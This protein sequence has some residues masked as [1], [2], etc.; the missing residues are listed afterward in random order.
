MGVVYKARQVTLNRPVAL[1]MIRA[2][3]LA[4]DDELRRFQN[5]AEAV[6]LLDHPGIVSVYEVGEHEG[7]K[8]FSMKLVEGGNLAERLAHYKDNPRA[9]ATLLGAAAEAV[10]HAHM[11]GILH[12]TDLELTATGAILGTPAYMSPEQAAGRRDA[13][14][15]ATDIY[16]LGAILYALLT[17]QA[18][19]GGDSVVDTLDAVRNK[20]PEAPTKLN[21]NLPRDLETICLKCLEKDPRR[22]YSSAQALDDDLHN[23][24][25]SR[26]ITARRVGT[27]ERLWL[28]CKRR[29]AIAALG[30]AALLSLVCGLIGT[31]VALRRALRAEKE[32]NLQAASANRRLDQALEAVEDYNTSIGAEVLLGQK[33]FKDL[34]ER[35]LERPKRFYENL[36]TEL[37]STSPRDRRARLLLAR[38][39]H[40]LGNTL[41]LLGDA[42]KARN[43]LQESVR[44]LRELDAA[45]RGGDA[46]LASKLGLA[47]M[48]LGLSKYALGDLDGAMASER[49]A[50]EIF[51]R[52]CAADPRNATY[53]KS[54]ADVHHGIGW[55]QTRKGNFSAAIA[56]YAQCI[57]IRSELLAQD[58]TSLEYRA[59]QG[60]TYSNLAEVHRAKGEYSEA[61]RTA[62]E[63]IRILRGVVAARPKHYKNRDVLAD[64]Y[65]GLGWTQLYTGELESAASASREAVSI[66]TDL[67]DEQPNVAEYRLGLAAAQNN[68]GLV[69]D[70]SGDHDGACA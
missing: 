45:G 29:P 7:Q 57:A 67:V 56:A 30:A 35:L 47:S 31:S 63:A 23:W 22:R 9:A 20:P 2:G 36:A 59:D 18:P 4:D 60:T 34:R 13:I 70:A 44:I 61:V 38:G 50:A 52:L 48:R 6:A 46:E 10:H 53:R 27:S 65:A 58:P 55:A 5:E 43:E 8:Y 51:A 19:F 17:G 14:T 54:L 42:T 69:N 16:G 64:T 33:E 66:D 68:L 40:G 12:Q 37:S 26:P 41:N 62:L 25:E 28:W 21:V 24:L 32:A 3:V 15:T 49:E 11:R 39:R 1:K